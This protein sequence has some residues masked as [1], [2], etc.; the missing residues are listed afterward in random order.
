MKR[1]MKICA[2]LEIFTTDQKIFGHQTT[3]V[4]FCHQTT[5]VLF[6][7]DFR[8]GF[9]VEGLG[10]MVYGLGLGGGRCFL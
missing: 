8:I 5:D 1:F 3:D 10:F 4:M 9:I 2:F 7:R 6:F